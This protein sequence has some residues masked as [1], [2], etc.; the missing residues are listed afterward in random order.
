[1]GGHFERGDRSGR[2]VHVVPTIR[3]TRKYPADGTFSV[4]DLFF[5]VG[6]SMTAS[7]SGVCLPRAAA[8]ARP[9]PFHRTENISNGR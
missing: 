9:G 1:M 4:S 7:V 2:H 3:T 8:T 5:Q 6:K